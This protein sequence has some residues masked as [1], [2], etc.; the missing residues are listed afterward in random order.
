MQTNQKQFPHQ[1][2]DLLE[3]ANKSKYNHRFI[4][5]QSDEAYRNQRGD[6]LIKKI[7]KIEP[8]KKELR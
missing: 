1:L 3:N 4:N 2:A 8:F 7:D 5:A 6:K